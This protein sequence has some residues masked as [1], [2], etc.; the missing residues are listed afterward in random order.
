MPHLGK[1]MSEVTFHSKHGGLWIDRLDFETELRR[2]QSAGELSPSLSDLV[3]GFARDGYAILEGAADST[4]VDAFQRR[5]ASAF[6]NGD[7]EMLYQTPGSQ[8]ALSMKGGVTR[9]GNRAVDAFVA[10][11]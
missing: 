10:A 4:A 8:T 2:R 3:H 5:L 6:E 11:P 7:P 1:I 9:G